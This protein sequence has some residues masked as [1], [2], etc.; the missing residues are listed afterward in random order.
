MHHEERKKTFSFHHSTSCWA[1][2][3]P[4]EH[5]SARRAPSEP[6]NKAANTERR[7]R[8]SC[9]I[10]A[11][12][13]IGKALNSW[14]GYYKCLGLAHQWCR[15][16]E[17]RQANP[18]SRRAARAWREWTRAD[19]G[20]EGDRL[21]LQAALKSVY[22]LCWALG[23]QPYSSPLLPLHYSE[24]GHALFSSSSFNPQGPIEPLTNTFNLIY[25]S[26][27]RELI[28]SFGS[29]LWIISL[30]LTFIFYL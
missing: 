15:E 3:P 19:G 22:S 8:R 11:W 28:C 26:S 1:Q 2:W 9:L 13:R 16:R 7:V 14:V 21:G 10:R 30:L 25:S 20:R 5:T 12:R 17:Q 23:G 27:E 24:S 18:L 29:K 6:Q 4:T